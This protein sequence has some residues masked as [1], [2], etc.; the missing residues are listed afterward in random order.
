MRAIPVRH[1]LDAIFRPAAVAVIGASRARLSIGQEIL[2]NLVEFG[3][4][5]KVFPVNPRTEALR[6]MKCFPRV[7]DIPDRVDLAVIAVPR[8]KVLKVVEDCRRKRVRGLVVI[9]AGFQE[10]GAAGRRLGARLQA[11]VR[12]AGMRLVGPN[13][14]GVIHTDPRVRLNATFAAT[15]PLSGGIGFLSQSGALGE[16]ILSEARKA[17]LGVAMFASLGNQTD[18]EVNDLLEYWEHDPSVRVVLMYLEGFGNPSRF[19]RIA[20]RLAR[21]KPLIAVKAGRT[22]AGARAAFSHTGA[23]AGA[24]RAT[25]TLME[26]C[27]VLRAASIGEMF[28]LAA[29]FAAQAPPRGDRVAILT[30]AGGPAI[31]ATDAC[32]GLDLR[33]EPLATRTQA[34]LRR[35]LPE[36]A[37]VRNPVDL[38]ASAGP[39]EY[40]AALAALLEDPGVDAVIVIFVSP[41]L[42]DALEVARAITSRVGGGRKTVLAC[43]M[44]KLHGEEAVEHLRLAGVPVYSFPESAA[45]ALAAMAQYRRYRERPAGRVVRFR[46]ERGRAAGILRRARRGGRL[47]L[48]PEEAEEILAAYGFRPAPS[49][50]VGSAAEAVAAAVRIG[51]PVVLKVADPAIVHKGEVGGVIPDLRNGDEVARAFRILEQRFPAGDRRARVQR[52]IPPAREVILGM[53]QDPS[54]GPLIMLGTGG[55]YAEVIRDVVF[56]IHPVTDREAE[57]MVASLRPW[58]RG[59]VAARRVRE[60]DRQLARAVLRFSQ[61]VGDFPEIEQIE[62]NPLILEEEGTSWYAVDARA[63]RGTDS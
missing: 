60:S 7:T 49:R 1:P 8:Q 10:A 50:T 13:C 52:R 30:N 47:L 61:L 25:A 38:L 11:A 44:G 58:P 24:D 16:V 56:R 19:T 59:P 23:L 53:V 40:G 20:R 57:E 27:G 63:R 32:E 55:A 3:F 43:I 21:R 5:G 54:F 41:V 48:R 14:M 22:A 45:R 15:P 17:G 33:V 2:R 36:A 51:Y 34:R 37:S 18:V 62:V 4:Q 42:I 28:D 12:R 26:H 46:G 39:R 31:L 6:S 35:S 29:A 9:T